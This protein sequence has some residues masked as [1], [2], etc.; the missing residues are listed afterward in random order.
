MDGSGGH[1]DQ[2]PNPLTGA[3]SRPPLSGVSIAGMD[4]GC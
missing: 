4:Q 2:L 1:G 3:F